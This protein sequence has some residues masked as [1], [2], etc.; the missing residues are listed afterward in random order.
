MSKLIIG[1]DSEI[2]L[3]RNHRTLKWGVPATV[4]FIV[5]FFVGI[6]LIIK[7]LPGS[8][9]ET[10]GM[11]VCILSFSLWFISA[12]MTI[13]FLEKGIA[14]YEDCIIITKV[15]PQKINYE[16][17]KNVYIAPM[18][19]YT[20]AITIVPTPASAIAIPL[21][22]SG[23]TLVRKLIIEDRHHRY[24]LPYD[25]NILYSFRQIFKKMNRYL[26]KDIPPL[27]D[28]IRKMINFDIS[29][30]YVSSVK[31]AIY[32][33]IGASVLGTII[34]WLID[35]PYFLVYGLIIGLY[36]FLF[37][38]LP[39]LAYKTWRVIHNITIL[40]R[41]ILHQLDINDEIHS[42]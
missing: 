10:D 17:I 33:L 20:G 21:G 41:N 6:R 32:T 35:S 14:L 29:K 18:L 39:C 24:K 19:K 5:I 37:I 42:Y 7:A 11:V 22:P 38:F 23:Y 26:Q 12:G 15:L 25:T 2:T 36:I 28:K 4:L 8:K 3:K 31:S 27:T 30:F 40:W 34:E 16:D 1:E 13:A 9:A